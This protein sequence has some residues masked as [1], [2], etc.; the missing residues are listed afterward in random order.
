MT[1]VLVEIQQAMS[2][3][4]PLQLA[5]VQLGMAAPPVTWI[6]DVAVPLVATSPQELP[7]SCTWILTKV[8]EICYSFGLKINL[9]PTK[10]EAVIAFRGPHARECRSEL[11]HDRQGLIHDFGSGQVFRCVPSYEH[12]GTIYTADGTGAAEVAHRVARAQH[13]HH[14]VCKSILRNRHLAVSTRLRLLEG[15]VVPVLFHGAGAWSLLNSRQLQRLQSTY[16]K[17]VRG[18]VQN[19]FWAPAMQTDTHLLMVWRLPSVSLRLAKLRLLYAFHLV[20][21]LSGHHH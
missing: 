9:K 2:S 6:D 18:I 11:F 7:T 10:T 16:L 3:Y 14:E 5:F 12:L 21:G 19:G 15:L 1:R 13:A 20:K 17:W 4:V 8:Q